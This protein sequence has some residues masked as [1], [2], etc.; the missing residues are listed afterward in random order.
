MVEEG[1]EWQESQEAANQENC[2]YSS[3]ESAYRIL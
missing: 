2:N 3:R 1:H